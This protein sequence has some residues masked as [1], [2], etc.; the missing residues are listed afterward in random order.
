MPKV[1]ASG[2]SIPKSIA[3]D[4]TGKSLYWTN[5]NSGE[6]MKCDVGGCNNAPTALSTAGSKP[7][8][9]AVDATTVYWTDQ[10]G[11]GG[12]WSCPTGG[13]NNA[14]TYPFTG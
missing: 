2:Q 8:G 12:V 4:P 11:G 1:L 10:G 14:P 13:C 3:L 9:I 6:V 7:Y 5:Y